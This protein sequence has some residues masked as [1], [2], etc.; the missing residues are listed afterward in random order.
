MSKVKNFIANIPFF[1]GLMFKKLSDMFYN[2]AFKFH[3]ALDTEAG[4]KLKEISEVFKQFD[5][6]VKT[7]P[8]QAKH[9][10]DSKLA[11]IIKGDTNANRQLTTFAIPK[12]PTSTDS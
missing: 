1:I 11:T 3:V 8:G 6:I 12:K 4:R 2:I 7:Q 5:N 10:P 9:N